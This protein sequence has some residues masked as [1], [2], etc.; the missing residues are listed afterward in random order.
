M[1]ISG[2]ISGTTDGFISGT[3]VRQGLPC[4]IDICTFT[5]LKTKRIY[6]KNYTLNAFFLFH[7][8]DK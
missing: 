3:T 8:G 4:Q 5:L 6:N 1:I 2:T 7:F